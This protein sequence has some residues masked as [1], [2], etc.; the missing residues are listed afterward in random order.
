MLHTVKL[1]F[2]AACLFTSAAPGAESDFRVTLLGTASP[3]PRP[4][5]F[6]PSTLIEAGNVKLLVDAGRGVPI[7]L[8]QMRV[9]MGQLDALLITHY[10]SDHVSGVPDVWLT[11]WLQPPFGQRKTPFHVIGPTGAKELM[12]NL[13]RA[14]AADI[15]IRLADEKN[16]PEGIAVKVDEFSADGVVFE[17]GGVRV[18]AF[19]VD[20]GE[21]IKPAYGYRIDYGGRSVV[22]S[23]DTRFSENVI[24][25]G[26][27]ADLL[28]H[29]L[30]AAKPELLKNP[31][32]QR[33]IDHHTTPRDVGRVFERA[34]PK[35]AVYTHIVRLSNAAIPEPSLAEILTETRETYAGPLV[36]GE[37]LMTFDVSTRGVAVY[38]SGGP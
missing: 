12:D 23:G 2:I 3:S 7:R 10:H 27:G 4:D 31:A 29:E 36:F 15:K 19:A 26:T 16:P 28:I 20:H 38:R 30:G 25:H 5:R 35:L 33:I 18:T 13:Q 1:G 9:P 32:M 34:K 24:K 14:Y 6:G 8:W 22:I 17:K 37:D 11:G 21:V